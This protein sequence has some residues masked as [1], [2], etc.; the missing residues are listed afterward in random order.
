MIISKLNHDQRMF[1]LRMHAEGF[2]VPTI[3]KEIKE[4]FDIDMARSSLIGTCKA[5]KYKNIVEQ[6]RNS[7]LAKVKEVPI[8]NKRYRLEDS[9]LLREKILKEIDRVDTNTKGGKL[10]LIQL[11]GELRRV[12]AEAREEMEKKP[13]LVQQAIINMGEMSDDQLFEH[14]EQLIR[15]Y[16]GL[17]GGDPIGSGTDSGSIESEDNEQ[18]S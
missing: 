9:Q 11:S 8:A 13:Q 5:K 3:R 6:F 12:N 18:P 1:V 4:K 2:D 14:K 17:T 15:R 10:L 16:R 7:Y